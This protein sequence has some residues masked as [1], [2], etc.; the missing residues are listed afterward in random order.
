MTT[1]PYSYPDPEPFQGR[2]TSYVA[3]PRARARI[4]APGTGSQP[5]KI[6]DPDFARAT[7]ITGSKSKARVLVPQPA[8]ASAIPRAKAR[9]FGRPMNR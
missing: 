7:V 3:L 6:L 5:P 9:S 4:L 1:G 8:K 2:E